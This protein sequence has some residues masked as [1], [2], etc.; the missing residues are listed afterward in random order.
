MKFTVE[1]EDGWIEDGELNAELKRQVISGIVN[2]ITPVLA[3]GHIRLIGETAKKNIIKIF[4]DAANKETEKFILEGKV[5]SDRGNGLVTVQ[6]FIKEKFDSSNSY[7]SQKE[8]IE[9]LAKNY[10]IEIKNRYDMMFASQ[11]VIKMSEQGLLKEGVLQS[12]MDKPE[13][14]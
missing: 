9:K 14:K 12:L 11:L 3:E 13:T 6:E 5:K 10:S 4:D 8:L 1:I 7:S 2:Q